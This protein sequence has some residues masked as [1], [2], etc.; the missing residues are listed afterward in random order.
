MQLDRI[1]VKGFKS[2]KE[3]DIKLNALNI[4]I[5]ANGSGKT[6]FITLF[7]LL[8]Q[9]VEKELQTFVGKSGGADS[10]LFF[11]SQTT[12]KI[13]IRLDFGNNG[14]SCVLQPSSNDRFIFKNEKCFFQGPGYLK[15]YEDFLGTGHEE[16]ML[17]EQAKKRAVPDYALKNMKTWK[18]YHFQDTS[19][20]AKVKKIGDIHDN[21]CLKPDASNLAAFL[22]LLQN[23]YSEH[24]GNIVDTISLI[25]PFFKDFV[26]RPSPL[27]PEK[28]QLEWKH[29]GSDGYFNAFSFS[30]GTLRFICLATLL[31]QPKLPKTILLDEPELGL[32]PYAIN[33]LSDLLKSAAARTQVIVSTQSV[34]LVNQFSH[35]DIIVVDR[36]NKHSVFSRPTPEEIDSWIDD[37]SLGELWEKNILRGRPA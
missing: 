1:R 28:I 16:T 29:A 4:L 7:E 22:Y 30:D 3:L 20:T 36:E 5:G 23:K 12:D 25:A 19:S 13:S 31:L 32:H 21:F 8:N 2:I 6:N 35:E 37:Y 11:G 26:L 34:T 33:V 10:F 18:V 27:N 24:Y 15:P 9:I 14:Y 17:H